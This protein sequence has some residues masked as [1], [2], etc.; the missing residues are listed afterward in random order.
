MRERGCFLTTT[1]A[2]RR[3]PYRSRHPYEVSKKSLRCVCIQRRNC[4]E[5]LS[6]SQKY[7]PGSAHFPVGTM[8]Q[9]SALSEMTHPYATV[10]LMVRPYSACAMVVG[11]AATHGPMT[12]ACP[13]SKICLCAR[14]PA[15]SAPT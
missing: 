2:Q 10:V 15:S 4:I 3:R 11:E 6:P 9:S 5:Q 7:A 8:P 13:T 1:P 12:S 14:L